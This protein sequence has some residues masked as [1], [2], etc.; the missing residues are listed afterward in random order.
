MADPHN[1]NPYRA[2]GVVRNID[3]WYAAF[4]VEKEHKLYLAPK[5]RIH[6]W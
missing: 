3:D 5:D 6:I 2:N 4:N 1:P